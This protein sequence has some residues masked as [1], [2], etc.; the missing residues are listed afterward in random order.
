MKPLTVILLLLLA[1]CNN[2][3]DPELVL[4][5][6]DLKDP[7]KFN[8]S[9]SLL[10]ISGITLGKQNPDTFYAIQ[11]E[12]GK[13]FRFTWEEKGR[14]ASS[15]FAKSG[16]YEDLAIIGGTV[17]VLK[18]NGSIFSFALAD[19]IYDEID[20]VYEWKKLLPKGEYEG[21]FGDE[22]DGKLYI[23]CKN[24][25]GTKQEETV[26]GYVFQANAGPASEPVPAGAFEIDVESIKP[27]SGSVKKGFRPSGLARHPLTGDWYIISG[28]NKLLVVTGPDWKVKSGHHLSSNL[29]NQPEGIIFDQQG[30]LY[31]SNEGDDITEG[32]VLRFNYKPK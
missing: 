27:F 23:L 16:D 24:C 19:A 8:M 2:A 31:I 30:N 7:E 18:S 1:G 3:G 4:H 15:K 26:S 5:G 17:F 9:S 13:L 20:S 32:N 12:E 10:E 11:D 28:V 21:M 6:Y 22:R 14:K 29:F 25:K